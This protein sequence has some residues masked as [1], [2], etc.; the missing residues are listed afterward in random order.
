M[1]V[2][3]GG[4]RGH[5]GLTL[6]VEA[7]VVD[8]VAAGVQSLTGKAGREIFGLPAGSTAFEAATRLVDQV[9]SPGP[10]AAAR[11]C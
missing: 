11:P 8:A 7:G 5:L 10:A 4:L 3:A 9:C 2:S 6:G 1:G